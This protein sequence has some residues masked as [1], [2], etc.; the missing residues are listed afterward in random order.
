MLFSV[1]SN[2]VSL[3]DILLVVVDFN[4]LVG[5]LTVLLHDPLSLLFDSSKSLSL[6]NGSF[7]V[8]LELIELYLVLSSLNLLL[9]ILQLRPFLL[10]GE[11]LVWLVFEGHG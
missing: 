10:T 9:G 4:L 3:I 2:V 6:F 5:Y 7:S 8:L 11:E 1:L